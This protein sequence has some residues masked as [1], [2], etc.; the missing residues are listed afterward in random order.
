MIY[1]NETYYFLSGS[2]TG[3]GSITAT[4]VVTG[5]VSAPNPTPQIEDAQVA[6]KPVDPPTHEQGIAKFLSETCCNLR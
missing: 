1:N 6:I 5:D 2:G 3:A 4:A